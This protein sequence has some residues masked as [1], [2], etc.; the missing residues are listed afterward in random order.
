MKRY[1][2]SF[3]GNTKTWKFT[4][5]LDCLAPDARRTGHV[6]GEYA[7]AQMLEVLENHPEQTVDTADV[8][9]S[10]GGHYKDCDCIFC[11]R[12]LVQYIDMKGA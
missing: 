2:W 1:Y 7:L 12:K 10:I 5:D 8:N 9:D 11:M 3:V 6:D 4:D